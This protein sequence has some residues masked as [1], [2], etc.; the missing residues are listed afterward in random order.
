MAQ[1]AHIGVH[2][3]RVE[4]AAYTEAAWTGAAMPAGRADMILD[5]PFFYVV[6]NRGQVVFMGICKDPWG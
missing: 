5:R 2:E 4:A 1:D 3:N 6:K